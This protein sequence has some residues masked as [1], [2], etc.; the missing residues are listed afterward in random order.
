[1]ARRKTPPSAVLIQL[2]QARQRRRIDDYR[3]QLQ[4]VLQ[5]NQRAFLRLQECGRLFSREG[6]PA[7]RDLLL[8]HQNLLA[9]LALLDGLSDAGDVPAPQQPVRVNAAFRKLDRLLTRTN[10]LAQKT[11]LYLARLRER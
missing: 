10:D 5:S 11:G 3:R 1:M 7:G 8:T 6:L 9:A 4:A 2:D